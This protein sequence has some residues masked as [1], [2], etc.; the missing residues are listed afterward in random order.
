MLKRTATIASVA[1]LFV[2]TAMDVAHAQRGRGSGGMARPTAPSNRPAMGGMNR[3]TGGGNMTRPGGSNFGNRPGID[4]RLWRDNRA[5]FGNGNRGPGSMESG[6]IGQLGDNLGVVGSDTNISNTSNYGENSYDGGGNNYGSQGGGYRGRGVYGGAWASPYYGNW[7]RG[8]GSNLGSFRGGYSIGGPTSFGLGFAFSDVSDNPALGSYGDGGYGYPVD[9]GYGYGSGEGVYDYFPTWGV[10][11]VGDWGLASLASNWLS[12]TYVNPYY[13]TVVA[14]RPSATSVVYDYAQPINVTAAPRDT[15]VAEST[16]QVFSAARDSF[17]ADDYQR[18]LDLT[19]Q[20]IKQTPNAPVV[21]EFR[22]LC[23]FALKRYDEAA[24]V[25]YAVLWAGP[26]WNWSTLVG[27]YPD[28]DTYTDQ[29]RGLE[30]AV[31]SNLNGT[32]ERF[33]LDYHYLVQGNE[34]AARAEF[35]NVV[36]LEPK[37]QLA[38]SIAKAL[39]KSK[40]FADAVPNAAS[41][42]A[43]ATLTAAAGAGSDAGAPRTTRTGVLDAIRN[44]ASTTADAALTAAARVGG[45]AS[46]AKPMTK[47]VADAIGNAASATADAALTAAAAAGAGGDIGTAR[48]TARGVLGAIRSAASATAD[49]ALTAADAATR[50][51]VLARGG[52]HA[53]TGTGTATENKPADAPYPAELTG[54][55]KAAPS[56]NTTITLVLQPDSDFMWEVAKKGQEGQSITGRAVYVNQ[57]LGLTQ[58]NGPSLSGKVESID[59]SKFIFHLMGGGRNAPTVAFTR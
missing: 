51:R 19:D 9:G 31:R 39:N 21:H 14:T 1:T 27:L 35:A 12:S 46:G 8:W 16:E 34:D 22:A 24:S 3:P 5:G 50:G 42:M 32:P 18:A 43:D 48:P 30:G 58:E 44:A 57:V 45:D 29:L 40:G 20:V 59:K 55:W 56:P 37:D 49:A 33:L 47:G 52:P 38:A 25:A 2:F 53:A 54:T 17:K 41:A 23:L 6:N 10:S 13:A 4:N 26:C 36:K 11:S 7:Y 15:S 28:V